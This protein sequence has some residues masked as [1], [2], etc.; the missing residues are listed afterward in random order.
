MS[1]RSEPRPIVVDIDDLCD[2][3]DP[4][5]PLKEIKDKVPDFKATMFAIPSRCSDK[6]LKRYMDQDEWLHLG[7]HGWIHTRG[8]CL[9]WNPDEAHDKI[10]KAIGMGYEEAFKAPH[11]IITPMIYSACAKLK[12]PVADHMNYRCEIA[13]GPPT[14]TFNDPDLPYKAFHFHTWDTMANGIAECKSELLE[15]FHHIPSE[16]RWVSEVTTNGARPV[17]PA[18]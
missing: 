12:M 5:D 11:W 14:Y 13:N 1:R 3:Y 8:E 4:L 15:F 16:F 7:M 18:T 9:S 2:Q 17:Q 6:L 10:M